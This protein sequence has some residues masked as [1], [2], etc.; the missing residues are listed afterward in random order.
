M[1]QL[2]TIV[3]K[4]GNSIKKETVRAANGQK[5][6]ISPDEME[7]MLRNAKIIV[8][9]DVEVDNAWN[10]VCSVSMNLS[11]NKQRRCKNGEFTI[12]LKARKDAFFKLDRFYCYLYNADGQPIVNRQ[13]GYGK[14]RGKTNW[15]SF[16]IPCE[17]IWQEGTYTLLL[18]DDDDDSLLRIIFTLDGDT[19]P[20]IE[21]FRPSRP[22]GSGV[23]N[24]IQAYE[25]AQGYAHDDVVTE[26]TDVIFELI[27]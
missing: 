11:L 24:M 6:T 16:Q 9:P 20:Q 19:A 21:V 2:K 7:D 23:Y 5:V 26:P 18:H 15:F 4:K 17:N 14:Y 13:S 25:S 22:L 1:P 27:V 10:E 3:M 8:K 12:D